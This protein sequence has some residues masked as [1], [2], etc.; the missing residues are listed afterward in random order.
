[1]I[2]EKFANAF[3][4]IFFK[5]FSGLYIP[6]IDALDDFQQFIDDTMSYGKG[7]LLFFVPAKVLQAALIITLAMV[8][9]KY[10][11]YL[12]MWLLRKI[13]VASIN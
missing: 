9:I 4:S 11:Y 12:I 10:I 7:W 3:A 6:Q 2:I 1:M 8:S 5:L 13:P